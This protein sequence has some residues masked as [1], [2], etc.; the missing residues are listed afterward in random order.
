MTNPCVRIVEFST[1][2]LPETDRI[3]Y[4]R[5][6]YGHVVLRADF[7]PARDVA[8]HACIASLSLPG[9]QLSEASS[10]PVRI[11]RTGEYLADGN[12]DF[13]LTINRKGGIAT[14]SS[15]GREQILREQ[16]AL[17]LIAS[18]PTSFCRTNAG[19]SF[20]LRVP[21]AV[22]RSITADADGAVMRPIPRNRGALGLLS[23]YG[24]WLLRAGPSMD[25]ELLNLSVRHI[26][27]VLALTLGAAND[28]AEIAR[29]RG[30]RAARLKIAKDYILENSHR[31]EI[32]VGSV[33][34][35]LCVTPRYLQ[36]LFEETGTTFSEFLVKQR[37]AQAHR[38]L[39][40]SDSNHSAISTIAYDV[41]FGDLS[42]FN[43]RFRRQYGRT[44]RDIRDEKV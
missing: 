3:S 38:L 2:F 33:A 23:R 7:E 35:H 6:H 44:P 39:S 10:S 5:E 37:L 9:L 30:L 31:R 20:T 42:Y 32:S 40:E 36:R 25:S 12:D 19:Q 13:V 34:A 16:E 24:G 15:G 27:D 14:I 29:T 22:L 17:L 1:D 11:S 21:R 41:G 26:H 28:F 4:W 18:E 43:R 8:F